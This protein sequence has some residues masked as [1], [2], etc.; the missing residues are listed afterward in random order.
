MDFLYM[1]RLET[2]TLTIQVH[3]LQ[4]LTHTMVTHT[5]LQNFKVG[6][7]ITMLKREI[8]AGQIARYFGLQTQN[9]MGLQAQ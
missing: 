5:A 8:L 3:P 9:I 1:A 6:Y 2:I 4:A 7:I